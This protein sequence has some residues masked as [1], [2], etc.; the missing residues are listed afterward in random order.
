MRGRD[1]LTNLSKNSY[2]RR[3]RR[4]TFSPIGIPSR[5]LNPA[6][7]LRASVVIGCWP[8]MATRS[9]VAASMALRLSMASAP[10]PMFTTIF[11]RRGTCIVLVYSN[12]LNSLRPYLVAERN[13][14]SRRPNRSCRLGRL[15]RL[16]GALPS[17]ARTGPCLVNRSSWSS[18]DYFLGHFGDSR[19]GAVRQLGVPNSS[20]AYWCVDR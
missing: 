13:E 18:L 2:M 7:D 1:E 14:K 5:I 20:W 9:R 8:V 15:F 19:L 3:P 10:M 16:L 12:S 17:A 11:S 6:I 4:V